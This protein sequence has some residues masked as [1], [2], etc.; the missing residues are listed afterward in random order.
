MN[1]VKGGELLR[2]RRLFHQSRVRPMAESTPPAKPRVLAIDDN[3]D[4]LEL[5]RM[6]LQDDY[7]VLTLSDPMDVYEMMELF[8]PDLLIVDIMMPRVN[9]FQLIEMLQRNPSTRQ[10]PV[11]I[12][13]A[14]DNV[15]DI[16]HGY[17]LGAAMY[18]TKPFQAERL[19]KNVKT[20]FE[21]SPPRPRAKTLTI[22][23]VNMQLQLKEGHRRGFV[24]MSTSFL[25]EENILRKKPGGGTTER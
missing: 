21:V 16:K 23:Q 19:L 6:T 7:D 24:Q 20:Q 4:T 18:L 15:R 9:G 1:A 11:I 13:S 22:P 8:E 3:E 10:V 12:L 14:K 17:K 5:V 25:K 2:N